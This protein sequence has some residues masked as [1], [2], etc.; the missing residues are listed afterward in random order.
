MLSVYGGM[1]ANKN[2]PAVSQHRPVRDTWATSRANVNY[3]VIRS[4]RSHSD[5]CAGGRPNGTIDNT[6]PIDLGFFENPVNFRMT[7]AL[8]FHGTPNTNIF[9]EGRT[10]SRRIIL[11][12]CLR[13]DTEVLLSQ[14][15][16]VRDIY[17]P[18]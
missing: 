12:V 2:L 11:F 15:E 17:C 5:A 14:A 4:F 13:Y 9:G 3:F 1:G 18:E 6:K 8:F 16:A 7:D 10:V